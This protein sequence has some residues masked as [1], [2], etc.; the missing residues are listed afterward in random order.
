MCLETSLVKNP[1][2]KDI[3]V[4]ID[5][6]NIA[7]SRFNE[8]QKP[9]LSDLLLVYDYLVKI[10]KFKQENIHCIC[11]PALKYYI[12]KPIDYRG[13]IREGV[14]IEAPKL[15]DEFILSF[16]LKHDTCFIISND[17]FR[18]YIEQL[19]SRQWLE[20]RRISFMIINEEVCLSPNID[21]TKITDFF[22]YRQSDSPEV[23]TIDILKQIERSEGELN[24][25]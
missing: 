11:D 8:L 15:A 12:D 17:K 19:P 5:G 9:V 25:F 1:Y 24:L 18:D 14:I 4:Y 10:L 23:T 3:H 2:L 16:A 22:L 13:L 20:E 21:Y 6:S 7:Y